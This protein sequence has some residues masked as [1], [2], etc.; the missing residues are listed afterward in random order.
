M[1]EIRLTA[2]IALVTIVAACTPL[3]AH[4]ARTRV[5]ATTFRLQLAGR[6]AAGATF[7]VAYGPLA[8]R[9][10]IIQ[11]HRTP[12]GSYAATRAL[13]AQGKTVF[14]YLAGQ[15]V[16]HSRLGAVPGNPVVTIRSIGP[17]AAS[18]LRPSIVRWEPPV[19]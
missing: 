17:V 13:P 6:P 5:V 15:G 16:V 18:R 4:A 7:W 11:L 14:S 19:G 12:D 1:R 3:E 2:L 8:G 10:G 9:F